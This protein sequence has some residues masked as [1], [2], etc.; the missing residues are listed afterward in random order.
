M[1]S[2]VIDDDGEILHFFSPRLRTKLHIRVLQAE[3]RLPLLRNLGFIGKS[4]IHPSQIA[5]AN[6][7]FRP[8]DDELAHAQRVVDA[9]AEADA[10]GL[11]AYVVDGKMVD[12]PF[13]ARAR[14]VLAQANR[15]ERP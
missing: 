8:S 10:K 6:A 12:A 3:D 2:W 15:E 9:A 13:V 5:L 7:V 14:A 1:S 11:G 4:C